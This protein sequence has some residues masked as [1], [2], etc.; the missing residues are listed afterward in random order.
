M[1]VDKF[2]ECYGGGNQLEMVPTDQMRTMAWNCRGLD[3]PFK[4][5]QLKNFF[6]PLNPNCFLFVKK[7]ERRV[8]VGTVCKKLGLGSRW[9]W[10][11]QIEK[12]EEFWWDRGGFSYFSNK[13]AWFLCRSR[14]KGAR[15]KKI[16]CGLSLFM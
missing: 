3:G 1:A 12:V 6:R 13:N 2:S 14:S 7:R 15:K 4:I 9:K 8:F 5:S 10:W 11:S 16:E